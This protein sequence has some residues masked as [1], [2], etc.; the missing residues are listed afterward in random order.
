MAWGMDT[1][2][3]WAAAIMGGIPR[4][5]ALPL[6]PFPWRLRGFPNLE[7]PAPLPASTHELLG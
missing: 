4:G 2:H 1:G 3:P 5:C 6:W 7:P